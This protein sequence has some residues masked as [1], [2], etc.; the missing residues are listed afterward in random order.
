MVVRFFPVYRAVW[1]KVRGGGLGEIKEIALKRVGSPPPPIGS[2]FLDDR[3]S[4]GVLCDLLIHDIDYAMW[5]AGDVTKVD[6][7]REGEGQSQYGYITLE[8]A[9]GVSSRIEGGWV[10]SPAGLRT[11]IDIAGSG[12]RLEIVPGGPIPFADLPDEDPYVAQLRHF[13]DSLASQAPF[14]VTREEV[15]RVMRVVSAVLESAA[16]GRAIVLEPR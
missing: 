15:L 13:Q 14:L 4:A 12:G 11:T 3:L 7:R 8:H 5:L 1:E 16:H 6:A 10:A 9:G 2:W